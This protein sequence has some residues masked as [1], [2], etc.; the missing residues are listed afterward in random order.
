MAMFGFPEIAR[1]LGA[2]PAQILNSHG[3]PSDYFKAIKVDDLMTMQDAEQL[4][5]TLADK[6]KA[7]HCGA[8]M[9]SRQDIGF[10]GII[11]YIMQQ[12]STVRLALDALHEHLTLHHEKGQTGVAS[13][14]DVSGLYWNNPLPFEEQ[15]YTNEAAMAQAAVVLRA[16][17]GNQFRAKTVHFTHRAPADIK[18]YKQIFKAP[19]YFNQAKNEIIFDS[20]LLKKK[21]IKADPL[22]KE[23]LIAKIEKHHPHKDNDLLSEVE[24]LIRQ[25]LQGQQYQIEVIA[26]HLSLHPRTLQ[27]KLQDLGISYSGLLEKI[28]RNIA[29]ERLANADIS[30][31]QLSD[32]LGYADNTALTRAFKRWFGITPTEWKKKYKT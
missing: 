8:L 13:Y 9:G 18:P 31:T 4:M 24:V 19:V 22:L 21:I 32:Y 17:I 14:G 15:H 3:L 28:R 7:H 10:L 2:D 12:S 23:I 1:E 26:K 30:I 11:G 5:E 20:I 25:S 29:Q 16:I 6:T 27:R